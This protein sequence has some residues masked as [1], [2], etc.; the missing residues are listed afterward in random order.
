MEDEQQWIDQVPLDQQEKVRQFFMKYDPDRL[1]QHNFNVLIKYIA[2]KGFDELD[3]KLKEKYGINITEMN[4]ENNQ[5]DNINSF[6]SPEEL[7]EMPNPRT[8]RKNIVSI[9]LRAGL[10]PGESI[11]EDEARADI[12]DKLTL[13]YRKHNPERLHQGIG[14]VVEYALKF[15]EHKLN[16]KLFQQYGEDLS[17]PS[18]SKQSE[19]NDNLGSP[20]FKKRTSFGEKDF[21]NENSR[22][23]SNELREE[24]TNFFR[25][26]EPDRAELDMNPLVEYAN[27]Q[28][29]DKLNEKLY[30]KYGTNLQ[31]IRESRSERRPVS[32]VSQPSRGSQP[33]R[34]RVNEVKRT[35]RDGNDTSGLP[36]YVRLMLERFYARYDQ[37]MLDESCL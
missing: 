5:E 8:K 16:A 7:N 33:S 1:I 13:F 24:L 12:F 31:L 30:G 22:S 19:I 21:G 3:K 26:V 32:K 25:I 28:G 10:A 36:R 20:T 17:F 27:T 29:L 6:K 14:E 18:Q 35:K 37:R 15:G 9:R 2:K 11:E 23:S 4:Q 34:S